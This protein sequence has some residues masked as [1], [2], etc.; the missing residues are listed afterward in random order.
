MDHG[1]AHAPVRTQS[2]QSLGASLLPCCSLLQGLQG[3]PRLAALLLKDN[4]LSAAQDMNALRGEGAPPVVEL[5][6]G[7]NRLDDALGVLA[8]LGS[9]PHLCT[10]TLGH[11]PLSSAATA[12]WSAT[13]AA[14]P[15]RAA[16]AAAAAAEGE[17]GTWDVPGAG[18]GAGLGAQGAHMAP[19]QLG[20][21]VSTSSEG[22]S[23]TARADG[24]AG[25]GAAMPSAAM[26][27]MIAHA[28]GTTGAS[29]ASRASA[30]LPHYR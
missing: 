18:A 26:P 25:D 17:R 4:S 7:H 3:L 9:L 5:D 14:S 27:T 16:A 1:T 19:E 10:L 20:A 11:N 23:T 30:V 29:T 6:L 21:A 15:S 22:A 12:G 24:T 8:V 13:A 2:L 28:D